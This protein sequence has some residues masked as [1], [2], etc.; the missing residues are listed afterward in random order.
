MRS[1]WVASCVLIAGVCSSAHAADVVISQVYG[2]GGNGGAI[3]QNDFVE[4]FN[5]SSGPVNLSGW[6]VQ[7]GSSTGTGTF[8][9]NGVVSLSGVL[10]PGQYYLVKLAAGTA[11]AGA[12]LPTPDASGTRPD[13]SGTAGKIVL[14]DTGGLACNGSNC[15]ADQLSHIVDFVGYGGA[16]YFEGSGPAP[17][18][19]TT[20]S[21]YRRSAGCT[22]SDNNSADFTTGAPA[23]RNTASPLSPCGSGPSNAPVIASC[24]AN[25]A[26]ELGTGGAANLSASD[27][28]GFVLSAAITSSP[29]SG[30]TLGPV[31]S[32]ATLNT[33]L[34]VS[35]S[36][37][38]G[39]Y[40]VTVTFTNS[41][42]TPQTASCTIAVN[43]AAP[44]GAVRIHDI[45]GKAH[46]S[47]LNGQSVSGV[48]GIVTGKKSNGFYM[49]D[50]NPDADV[51][52]SEGI[53]VF[54]SSAPSVSVGDSVKVSGTVQEFRPGGSD[55]VTNL[56]LTEIS[57]T[58]VVITVSSGNPL[59]AAVVIGAGGRQPPTVVIDDDATGSVETSG[60]FDATTDGVD[61]FESLE[62]M[63]VHVNNPVA[64][65]PT[66][67][68][69]ETPLLADN[70]VNSTVRTPRGGIVISATDFNADRIIITD[71]LAPQ[72]SVN[73]GATLSS[74]DAIV[75]Y[76]FKNFMLSPT[77]TVGVL[78]NT[79]TAETTAIT[80]SPSNLTVA[81]YNV[82]NLAATNAASK[83]AGLAT[84]IVNNLHSPDIVALMEVQD[85]NGA[86]DDGTVD[87]SQTFSK[88]LTAI[89]TAGGP[90][91]QVR[92]I[93]PVNDADGGEPGGNIRVAFMFNPA[94]V[95][96]TDRAGGTPTSATT[97][98]NVGGVPQLSASPGRIDPANSAWN[99]SRKPLAGEFTFNGRRL[100]LIANH[101]NSKGGDDPLYGRFQPP[102]RSSEIQRHQQAAL[103]NGFVKNLL[104]VDANAGVV[105][106]GDLNDFQFSDTLA[107]VK[108]GNVLQ[109]LID[110]LPANEQYSYVF[111]GNSQVLD[112]TLV[113][114]SL[115]TY[116][117]PVLDVVHANAE[118]AV[119]TS[120]HDP[121]VVRI[122]VPK[123]GDVDGD[124]DI[125]R[126][127]ITAITAARNTNPNGPF[128]PRDA[129]GDGRIDLT[130]VRFATTACTRP[131][132]AVQ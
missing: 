113:S 98:N 47:P 6:S 120:D 77:T 126:N 67:S 20:L 62:G 2:A 63:R 8:A 11:G 119:Q 130:D 125:D 83:F 31:T 60:T 82:E 99:A 44:S 127:D 27:A 132:C 84:Q 40:P 115:A 10:Q 56:T 74:F 52:T 49:Q 93:N 7:Y 19:S 65:G 79:L 70:G 34:L 108:D 94:R 102:V 21:L 68:F 37:A 121:D 16:N 85:N 53:F 15:T 118:F 103:V 24:P 73:V 123:A 87:A 107:V 114:N 128:D 3:Y 54:T 30:I 57:G 100:F 89:L 13:L 23:A 81:S 97:V 105:V 92:S 122:T 90:N 59:P 129:N 91:Y 45:Q 88:L 17:A 69:N 95:G 101:F 116:A 109:D 72:P 26:V 48:P 78:S 28:D 71:S 14:A 106:L 46:V 1:R 110:T 43:V 32:G 18:A 96:F 111:E 25:F 61:F 29:V 12:P 66:N 55:G 22:D 38:A 41:D 64:V 39:N 104:A 75:D 76:N 36:A 50:P 51:A 131:G 5:R 42:T 112:H 117:S 86:T 80:G 124:G 35:S 33:Q 4:L 9:N 58:P